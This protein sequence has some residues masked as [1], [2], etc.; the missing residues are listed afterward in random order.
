MYR[1]F[2]IFC[3]FISVCLFS[4]FAQDSAPQSASVLRDGTA[5]ELRMTKSFSSGDARV[6]DKVTFDVVQDVSVQ[7]HAVAAK[8][9][10]ASA[11]VVTAEPHKGRGHDGKLV[12]HLDYVTLADGETV[13]LRLS[14]NAKDPA[15]QA[16]MTATNFVDLHESAFKQSMQGKDVAFVQGMQT[17]AY[18]NGATTLDLARFQAPN[19][20]RD[21]VQL[22]RLEVVS[23]PTEAEVNVDGR[24]ISN[25]PAVIGLAPGIHIVTVRRVGFESWQET[26]Q[27]SGGEHLKRVVRLR[28]DDERG[29]T[30][31]NCWGSTDCTD[32]VGNV[33]D[34]AR[35]ARAQNSAK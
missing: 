34:A 19:A 5:V 10:T 9:G 25:T 2:L 18:I 8:G 3:A 6:G 30:L 12:I 26:M 33:A 28:S 20:G 21:E 7:G 4:A 24:F 35:A 15:T 22:T 14:P 1:A 17:I 13:E 11:T 32:S 23:S 31:S 27:V 16:L 29:S